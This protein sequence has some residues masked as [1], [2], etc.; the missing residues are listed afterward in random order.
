MARASH[1]LLYCHPVRD[2]DAVREMFSAISDR[3]DLLNHLLSA[4]LDRSWRRRAVRSLASSPGDLVLDLCGGTGDLAVEAMRAGARVVCCD[5]SEKMLARAERKF[6]GLQTRANG[7]TQG[8]PPRARCLLA[9]ALRLPFPDGTF[10]DVLVG[11]G[12][13]NLRSLEEGLDE[14][15]RVL[16]PGGAVCILEFSSPAAG[17][18]GDLYRLYLNNLLPRIGEFISRRRGSYGY[19]AKTIGEFPSGEA[20]ARQM[21]ERGYSNVLW[22]PLTGG[23]V[24]VHTGRRPS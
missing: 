11:F 15:R 18:L 13:R 22:R 20:L 24:A 12:L 17:V 9:D 6:A 10:E 5:F 3:Y 8:T 7:Q 2:P 16:R 23:I 19:L 1:R 4:G 14:I 21:S